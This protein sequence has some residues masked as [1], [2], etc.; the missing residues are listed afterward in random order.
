MIDDTRTREAA[1]RLAADADGALWLAGL[2]LSP[3]LNYSEV[4]RTYFG[5][6]ASWLKQ[7]LHGYEV[8]GKPCRFKPDETAKFAQALRHMAAVLVQNA[9]RI[10]AAR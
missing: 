8:N 4:A 9:D 6:S 5:R 3:F 1:R 10:E 2:E 7:R